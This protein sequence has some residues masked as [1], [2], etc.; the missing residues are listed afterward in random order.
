MPDTT[1]TF[2]QLLTDMQRRCGYASLQNGGIE[3]SPQDSTVAQFAA[4]FHD[5][6]RSFVMSHMWSWRSQR[7]RVEVNNLGTAPRSVRPPNATADVVAGSP[8]QY[9]LDEWVMGPGNEVSWWEISD[10]QSHHMQHVAPA[11]IR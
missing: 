11:L 8:W 9:D 10:G 6:A 3:R 4:D 7:F 2:G 5:A 1:R